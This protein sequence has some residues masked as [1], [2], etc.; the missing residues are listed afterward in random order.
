MPYWKLS[1]TDRIVRSATDKEM[2]DKN[3][4]DLRCLIRELASGL[5]EEEIGEL[6]ETMGLRISVIQ[7][8]HL[9]IAP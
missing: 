7:A 1:T 5:S 2:K 8:A 4:N 6:M 3:D 9:E